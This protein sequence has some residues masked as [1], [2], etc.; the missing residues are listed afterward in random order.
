MDIVNTT[1]SEPVQAGFVEDPQRPVLCFASQ[2]ARG[3]RVRAHRHPRAQVVWAV[4]GALRVVTDSASWI[5][6]P[7][8]AVWIPGSMRHQ[9]TSLTPASVRY[10]YIDASACAPLPEDAQVLEITPLMRELTLR[11]LRYEHILCGNLPLTAQ[12]QQ[13]LALLLPLLLDELAQLQAAPLY[14]PSGKDRRLR[15]LMQQLIRQPG[16]TA[17]LEQLAEA[18]GASARTLERLFKSETGMSF[19]QWRTRLKLLESVNRLVQGESS[20]SIAASLGY[21]S[22]SAFVAAFHR[23]FG[24]PPQ[25]FIRQPE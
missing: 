12:Q 9:V 24:K 22:S 2:Q 11:T 6:P 14:L 4:S 21:R 20:S 16:N 5:V 23:H 3:H 17:R 1:L 10:L 18:A 8:H 19:Q 25:S 7:T 13:R 15:S